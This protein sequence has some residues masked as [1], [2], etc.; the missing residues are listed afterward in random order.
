MTLQTIPSD[1]FEK[2][3]RAY[4]TEASDYDIKKIADLHERFAVVNKTTH[5]E[6]IVQVTKINEICPQ[7]KRAHSDIKVLTTIEDIEEVMISITG[8]DKDRLRGKSRK[9]KYV[10]PRQIIMYLTYKY[11]GS[12]LREIA[13]HYNRDHTTV[14]HSIRTV[15]DLIQVEPFT[16]SLV[17]KIE[18]ILFKEHN[19]L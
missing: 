16:A 5:E 15:E 11:S 14:I 2:M 18:E 19:I 10:I 1:N 3:L 13:E 7:C 4:L 6:K 8:V 17:N 12:F 9:R